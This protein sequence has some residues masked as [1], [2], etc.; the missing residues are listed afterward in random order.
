MLLKA[1]EYGGIP[2]PN[3]CHQVSVFRYDCIKGIFL[4]V[5]M[6]SSKEHC[7]AYPLSLI[8]DE[9]TGEYPEAVDPALSKTRVPMSIEELGGLENVSMSGI[10]AILLTR[11]EYE[12]ATLDI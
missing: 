1:S 3:A 11:P 6:W 5:S 12:G 9:E 2:L 7:E 8:P 4:E 10:Y